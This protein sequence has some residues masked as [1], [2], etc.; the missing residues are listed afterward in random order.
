L[1]HG[2]IPF[3]VSASL[4]HDFA[5]ISRTEGISEISDSPNERKLARVRHVEVQLWGTSDEIHLMVKD[6]GVGFDSE[7]VKNRGGLGLI[8]MEERLKLLK[9]TFSVESEPAGGTT[10]RARV[11]LSLDSKSMRAAG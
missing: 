4:A 6:S 8:S 1:C 9:G 3:L 7:A 2:I 10:I 5:L 11:P